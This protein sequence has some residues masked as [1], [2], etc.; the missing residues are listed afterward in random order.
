[1][2]RTSLISLVIL[3]ALSFANSSTNATQ[4]TVHAISKS[5]YTRA[6]SLGDNYQFH[7]RDGWEHVNI[8]NLQYK[9]AR[10]NTSDSAT[11]HSAFEK[12][13]RKKGSKPSKKHG[14]PHG[15]KKKTSNGKGD[16]DAGGTIKHILGG[17]WNGL[18]AIGGAEPVT[19]TWYACV[20]SFFE[21]NFTSLLGT[22][23][24]IYLTQAAG[25][26]ANGTQLYDYFD[27]IHNRDL[28]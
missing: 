23:G 22:L 13:G 5:K 7:R 8:T 16:S 6:H 25:V 4:G 17:A 12:R 1:M 21:L 19:I 11:A 18:K 10:S 9:Y 28:L 15:K 24:M 27:P 14:T 2:F 26:M 3:A 20:S